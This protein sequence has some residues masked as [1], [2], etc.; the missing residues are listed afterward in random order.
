MTTV[1]TTSGLKERWEFSYFVSVDDM[2]IV[3]C[4]F[5]RYLNLIGVTDCQPGQV[6]GEASAK[7]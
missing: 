5:E 4:K 7:S 3:Y 2:L 6:K 1:C